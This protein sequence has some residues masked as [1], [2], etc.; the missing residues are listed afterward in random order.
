[1]LKK[2]AAASLAAS[3][4]CALIVFAP[5]TAVASAAY[6]S[7]SEDAEAP[8]AKPAKPSK[9]VDVSAQAAAS[10]AA[11]AAALGPAASVRP[12]FVPDYEH[13]QGADAPQ[14]FAP[15]DSSSDVSAKQAKAKKV[16]PVKSVK[17]R[18]KAQ[19]PVPSK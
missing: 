17:A 18:A 4:G 5:I 19:A 1:M 13:V 9:S 8:A 11:R 2:L 3:I 7:Q 6:S 10:A 16:K 14:G 12:A 15:A